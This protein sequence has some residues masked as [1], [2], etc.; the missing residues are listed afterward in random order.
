MG[1]MRTNNQQPGVAAGYG[2]AAPTRRALADLAVSS[3]K[4]DSRAG[5]SMDSDSGDPFG[6]RLT[7][8]VSEFAALV[9]VGRT[10]AY[11]AARRGEIPVCRVGK[12]YVVPVEP[13][14]RWLG[15]HDDV[16][17][18]IPDAVKS[19]VTPLRHDLR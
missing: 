8:T 6:N 16:P 13:L 15:L 12:R 11:E 14:R 4:H 9:G 19:N 10:V 2:K 7:I 17:T 5:D 1:C 18:S 3:T